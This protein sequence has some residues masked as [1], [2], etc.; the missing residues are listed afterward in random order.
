[1]SRT[2]QCV[3][4]NKNI[5]VHNHNTMIK[6]RKLCP[7]KAIIQSTV[8]IQIVPTVPIPSLVA[9]GIQDLI[10]NSRERLAP[11]F[12]GSR[13]FHVHLHPPGLLVSWSPP[14]ALLP[15]AGGHLFVHPL[16]YC[17]SLCGRYSPGTRAED[18][19][20]PCR[21]LHPLAA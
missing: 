21:P 20:D 19:C 6:T 15:W 5:L 3:F 18:S 2:P 10:Q 1:M 12:S 13:L 9:S 11:R 4:P 17:L 8:H 7:D 16:P 14:T